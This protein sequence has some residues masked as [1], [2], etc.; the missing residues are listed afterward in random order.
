MV[1]FDLFYLVGP[2]NRLRHLT[3]THFDFSRMERLKQQPK[4]NKTDAGNG[5]YG[6]GLFSPPP[7]PGL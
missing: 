6:I 2:G 5:S 3:E 1:G 7:D 4:P